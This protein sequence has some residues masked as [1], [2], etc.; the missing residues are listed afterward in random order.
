VRIKNYLINP[1]NL[2]YVVVGGNYT[3]FGFNFRAEKLNGQNFFHLEWGTRLKG[4]EFEGKEFVYQLPDP[5]R[6]I[7][8]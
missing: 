7:L 1:G 6:V 3:D 5:D 8:L 4:S 2:A